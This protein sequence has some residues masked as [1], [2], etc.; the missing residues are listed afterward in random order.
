M[1]PSCFF[2]EEWSLPY[3]IISRMLWIHPTPLG[4]VSCCGAFSLSLFPSPFFPLF[5]PSPS[6]FQMTTSTLPSH[7]STAKIVLPPKGQPPSVLK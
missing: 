6:S 5:S 3:N 7:A 2:T 1:F 4:I